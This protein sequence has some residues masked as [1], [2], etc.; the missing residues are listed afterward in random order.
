MGDGSSRTSK[1]VDVLEAHLRQASLRLP[2][3]GDKGLQKL[4]E[5]TYLIGQ[6]LMEPA[7]WERARE[8]VATYKA[9][10]GAGTV[11][12]AVMVILVASTWQRLEEQQT[13]P[14]PPLSVAA[15][16]GPVQVQLTGKKLAPLAPGS[17]LAAKTEIEIGDQG[18]L[19]LVTVSGARFK[20]AGKH[21]IVVDR[22]D[23]P[24]RR[25][26]LTVTRGYCR[27][28]ATRLEEFVVNAPGSK[29]VA[30]AAAFSLELDRG[31]PL[32]IV[33]EG[34]VSLSKLGG[35]PARVDTGESASL[36]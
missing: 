15:I 36:E 18:Q 2:K 31:R 22:L 8:F 29:L 1:V 17:E 20:F 30:D 12:V 28:A 16:A 10:I 5:K 32:L 21:Q 27:F 24:A 19:E 35:P 3:G 11:V 14:L 4:R 34:S 7:L 9:L 13:A 23:A 25:I 26:E 6:G 33:D